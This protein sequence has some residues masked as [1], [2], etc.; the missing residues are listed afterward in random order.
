MQLTY[1]IV[2]LVSVV[3]P[4]FEYPLNVLLDPNRV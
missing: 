3:C 4:L 2:L 1:S